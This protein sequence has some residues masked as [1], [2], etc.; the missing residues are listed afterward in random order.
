MPI[1]RLSR[2]M[3]TEHRTERLWT[4]A[5]RGCTIRPMSKKKA[6][7]RE[8]V[9][10]PWLRGDARPIHGEFVTAWQVSRLMRKPE[11]GI[12]EAGYV[13]LVKRSARWKPWT[14]VPDP[15]LGPFVNLHS[16]FGRRDAMVYLA[17]RLDIRKAGEW[18]LAL[19]HDGG[20]RMFLDGECV[21]TEPTTRN[22]AVPARSLV[23]TR[24]SRGRHEVIVAF[25]LA[26]GSGW[27]IY[28]QVRKTDAATGEPLVISDL[29]VCTPQDALSDRR[30]R[31]RWK[32]MPYQAGRISGKCLWAL[33]NTDAPTVTLPLGVTGWHAI[34]LGI[35]NGGAE[36]GPSV[37]RVKLSGDAAFQH[38]GQNMASGEEV[39]FKCADLTGQDLQIAQQ[40]AGYPRP[41]CLFYVKLV[42]LREA[43]V[44]A[45]QYDLQQRAT[46]RLI[47]TIDGFSFL[48]ERMATTKAELLEEFEPFRGTDFGTIWWCISGA[49][50]VNY[51]S[52]LGTI[53]G[54]HTDDYPR[55]GDG[56]YIRA[57]RTLIERG[58]DITEVAA[59]ACHDM[60]I[61]VHIS[62]RPAAW[63]GPPPFEDYFTSNF[64]DAHPEWRCV[65]RD[66]TPAARMSFAVPEVRQHLLG[67]FRE[68]LEAEPDGLNMLY[69][70]GVPLVLWED[71]FCERFRTAYGEDARRVP[72]DDPRL[73]ELRA[74]ILT[75]WM[76]EV[77]QLLDAFERERGLK[78]HLA[79]SAMCLET[80]ADNRR[81]GLDVARWVR[82]G[83]IDQ[84]GIYRGAAHASGSPIDLGYYRRITAGTGVRVHPGLVSWA[85]PK[86]EDVLRQAVEWYDG[87]ADGLLLWDPSANVTD[88]LLWPIV[89]RLGHTAEVRL[90]AAEGAHTRAAF[91]VHALGTEPPSRWTPWAGF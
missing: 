7:Q 87:G 56:Y 55:P 66:G 24:L 76:R 86:P 29:S 33:V 54:E 14:A 15:Q 19:G 8:M 39:F 13:G 46:K 57:V 11:G 23:R 61:D 63:Q 3:C 6:Q 4:A 52:R 82:E 77:R 91:G 22:P 51:R 85:L 79:L 89:S 35:G 17:H 53:D 84:I 90:R 65:D 10:A 30:K 27:G 88:G 67:I 70:R 73:Y 9:L 28:L 59:N 12:A 80:E 43:D 20:A 36:A 44:A 21:L 72:E 38:R 49:D 69:N 78:R 26:N 48:Y 40:T 25:D 16:R 1:I 74:E 37:I 18:E 34:Y 75:E 31:G 68:V 47:G 32:I 64:Y 58:I 2:A 41:A 45:V 60:G 83:L 5:A 50:Q 42:P 81:F 71:A 62:M